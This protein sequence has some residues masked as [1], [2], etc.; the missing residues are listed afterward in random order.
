MK[1]IITILAA[2]LVSFAAVQAQVIVPEGYE[3]ADSV[4]Y[5]PI[6]AIDR[7][8]EGRD[9]WS[10]MPS[11]VTVNQSAAIADSLSIHIAHN[12]SK[13]VNGYRIRI[14]FDNKRE[15]RQESEAEEKRFHVLFPGYNTY[16]TFTSPFFKVTVGDFRTKTDANAALREIKAAFPSAFVV[17]EKFKYPAL[18]P[19]SYQV[20]TVKV[21]RRTVKTED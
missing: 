17:K 2:L 3:L 21:L 19:D 18:N 7:S 13:T 5:T 4:V 12:A 10:A 11:N 15:S 8:L 16:R 20:D 9:V 6:S 1:K 14:F